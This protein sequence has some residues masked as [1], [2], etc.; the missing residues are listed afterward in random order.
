MVSFDTPL[1]GYSCFD[2][3]HYGYSAE[4]VLLKASEKRKIICRDECLAAC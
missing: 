2:M 4:R 3:P 1:R